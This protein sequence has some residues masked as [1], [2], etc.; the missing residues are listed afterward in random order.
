M[1][2]SPYEV[3]ISVM[4][5]SQSFNTYIRQGAITG[6][7]HLLQSAYLDS[8]SKNKIM[9]AINSALG[10]KGDFSTINI[11]TRELILFPDS[12]TGELALELHDA[13][14][15]MNDNNTPVDYP[16]IFKIIL[17]ICKKLPKF[18]PF[19]EKYPL[20]LMN[21]DDNQKILGYY[22]SIG[23]NLELWYRYT[24]PENVGKVH[25]RYLELDDRTKPNAMGLV[26]PLFKSP[27]LAISVLYMNI[28]TT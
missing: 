20:R 4:N 7:R 25:L 24:P 21:Y 16:D 17:I 12:N 27:A 23:Y 8:T 19:I 2:R 1:L 6:L 22:Q 5:D 26:Y 28:C 10:D 11:R 9:Q 15:W 3:L 13:L 18:I 14:L